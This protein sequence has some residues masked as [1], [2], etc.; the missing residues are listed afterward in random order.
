MATNAESLY[1]LSQ[2]YILLACVT[3]VFNCF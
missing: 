2:Y 1:E 3:V